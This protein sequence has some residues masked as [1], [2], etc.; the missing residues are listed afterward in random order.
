M[1]GRS[2]ELLQQKEAEMPKRP[3]KR[4]E[5]RSFSFRMPGDMYDD[6]AAVARSRGVDMSAVL[7]WIL[8]EYHPTLLKKRTDHEKAMTEAIASREWEKLGSPSE[9]LHALRELLGRLQDEY[10]ALSKRVLEKDKRQAG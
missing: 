2:V 9:Q 8:A 3:V 7:N 1:I 6:I 4:Q 10:T 5:A